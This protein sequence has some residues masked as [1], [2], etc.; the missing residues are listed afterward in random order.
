MC[1]EKICYFLTKRLGKVCD[2]PSRRQ[3]RDIQ[4]VKVKSPGKKSRSGKGH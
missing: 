4:K 1:T 2:K 3:G